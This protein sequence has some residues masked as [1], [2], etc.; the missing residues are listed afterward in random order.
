MTMATRF[1]S[2]DGKI[3][4]VEEVIQVDKQLWVYYNN[5]KTGE[6]YSCSLDAFSEQFRPM[7]NES[8]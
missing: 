8:R 7:E 2:A 4:T 1:S 3:F 6:K 5:I